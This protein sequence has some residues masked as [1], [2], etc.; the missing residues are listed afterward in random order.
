M[1]LENI[2]K[3]DGT[4]LKSRF[5]YDHFKEKTQP[6]G[7]IIAFRAPIDVEVKNLNDKEN[8]VN[9]DIL[10]ADDAINFCMEIP[11]ISLFGGECFHRLFNSSLA[12]IL[13]SEFLNCDIEVDGTKIVVHK[14][15]QEAGIIRT[16][17]KVSVSDM[18]LANGAV[19]LYTGINITAGKKAPNTAFSSNLEGDE[20]LIVMHKGIELFYGMLQEI[21]VET[22]KRL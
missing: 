22:S 9:D 14:E 15:V 20:P 4:Y 18:S 6:I 13:A 8:I 16:Q 5:A 11:N 2:E 17:G 19:L 10:Y 1:I 12:N 7:N 21:F 3:Y